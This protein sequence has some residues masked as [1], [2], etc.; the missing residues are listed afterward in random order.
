MFGRLFA[1]EMDH[2]EGG[3]N[4]GALVTCGFFYIVRHYTGTTTAQ[5]ISL[6][7]LSL[8][9]VVLVLREQSA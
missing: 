3:E 2:M 7:I 6:R 9:R 1:R 5:V 8:L 4:V